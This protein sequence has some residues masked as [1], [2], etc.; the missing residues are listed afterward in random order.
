MLM[1]GLRVEKTLK[2]SAEG[3]VYPTEALLATRL[4]AITAIIRIGYE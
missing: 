2:S 3:E 4:R 1:G